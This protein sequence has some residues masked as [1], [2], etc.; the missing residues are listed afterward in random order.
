MIFNTLICLFDN[1]NEVNV[2][3]AEKFKV[4]NLVF[5]CTEC[6]CDVARELKNTYSKI[7]PNC[8]VNFEIIKIGNIKEV[9]NIL[10]KYR[11]TL[12]NLAGGDRLTALMLFKI[13]LERGIKS[14]YV[15]LIGKKKYMLTDEFFESSEEFKDMNI[16]DVFELSGV[17]II[18]ESSYLLEIKEI[19][20]MTKIIR[21]NMNIWHRYKQKLY[22]NKVF[23]HDYKDN[24]KVVINKKNLQKEE[25]G[26]LNNSLRY[27]SKINGIEYHEDKDEILVSFK[28]DYLKGFLFKSGT[29]LEVLTHLIIREIDEVDEVKSGVIFSWSN[30]AKEVRNEI[31][32][33]AI[34]DSVLICISCKDSEKYDEDALNELEVYSDKLGGED[35]IKILVAT[36]KPTKV[37]VNDRAKEMGINL[38]ILGENID[39][40]KSRI[41][42]IIKKS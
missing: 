24:Y 25:I 42:E 19:I 5:I 36:K 2:L 9:F 33:I 17:N 11:N 12:I 6:E 31:D 7:I 27:L 13:S 28:N 4:K 26:L 15:D 38:V 30:K 22:D 16:K 34:K 10:D 3:L 39:E 8:L 21:N 14:V 40:F 20:D 32:V 37:T 35:S 41:E 1:H 29:W 23:I 18:D